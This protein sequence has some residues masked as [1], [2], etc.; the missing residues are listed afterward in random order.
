MITDST[1]VLPL[2]V[3]A[4]GAILAAL[5]G[6]PALNR[7]ITIT[8]ASW[9]LALAPLLAFILLLL[10]VPALNDGAIF[11]WTW[12]WLPSLGLRLGFYVD[13][14]SV[15]FGLLITFIG[16]LVIVYTGQYFKGEQK[17]WRFLTYM[18]LFMVSMLGIVLAGDVITLFIFW[19]GTSILSFLLVA[20]KTKDKDARYGAFRA[21]F[22]TG[23]G[24]IAMLG[25]LLFVSYVA[26]GTDFVT[27]LT[28]G[29][30][31][32]SNEFYIV[33]LLLVTFGAFTKS[34]QFPAHIWLPGAM[35]APT[36]ASAYLHSATM[37][38][39]GIYLLARMNPALGFTE[40]WFWLLTI[41]GGMTM[42]TG[43]YL[44]LKQNDLKALLAYSTI[45]QLGVLVM[46]IGQDIAIAYKALVVGI[47]AHALYK[48]ALFLVAGIVDHETGTR[49]IRRL[50]G[51]RKVM[52]FTFATA[53]LAALSMAGLP[54][55]FGFLAKETLL[56]T[57]VHPTLPPVIAEVIRW[58]TVLAGAL[59]LAQAGL[60]I[61]E[62]FMGKPKDP[63]VKGHEAP[64]PMWLAP[65]IPAALSLFLAI[66][67]EA[68]EEAPFLAGAAT[69]AF[70]D[71]VK[72]TTTLFHG[73][74]VE[75]ALS[76]VAIS[77][78]T[79]IF[80]FRDRVRA[81]QGRILPAATF[82]KLY[83][84]VLAGID[85]GGFIATRVQQGNL[86]TYLVIIISST[87]L[88][89]F[90]LV[91]ANL[92]FE[93]VRLTTPELSFAGEM[94][95]LRV[96]SLFLVVTAAAATVVLRR[97]FAAVMAFG[98]SGLSMALIFVLEPA[99]DVAL[100]QIVVDMLS[101]VILVL[102]LIRLPRRQRQQAQTL[103][104]Q[105]RIKY[106]NGVR[107]AIVAGSLGFLVF[108]IT[109]FALISRPH[110]SDVTPYYLDNAKKLTGATDVVGAIVVDFRALDTVI[111]IGV[112]S[113]AGLGIYT[114]LR[115]A[116]RKHGDS[117]QS[118]DIDQ[119]KLQAFFTR[120]IGGT[121]ISPFIRLSVLVSLPL[122]MLLAAT[123][124]MYGHDQPGDG[125][126]AG[127]IISLSIGLWY[128]VFGYE[129]TRR[130]LPWLR[131]GM[132][133]SSGILLAMVTGTTAALITGSFLGNV[134]FTAGWSFLP[135]GFHIST[136]FLLEV[137]ICVTVL[138][139]VAY[140]LNTLG[141]PEKDGVI[142]ESD[143]Y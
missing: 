140:M 21:L 99:P 102:A 91:R 8:Q 129:E 130:Q 59:M 5:L 87:V 3:I 75:L 30:V 19:E 13:S 11:V 1:L 74:T 141:R 86:R 25:G 63:S 132:L 48:S 9:V 51:L 23:G 117:G 43:A 14:L 104:D 58:S 109:L 125:F 118:A 90:G 52:P 28:S 143:Q 29:D 66:Y 31:L 50:G 133:I 69:A 124:M 92:P 41:V 82:N 4:V 20:Y 135:T 81:W 71:S 128:V 10:R 78:G 47:L 65:A 113:V 18:L 142:F 62:T 32:R 33:F 137:A 24:G 136:S 60:F 7:R 12:E 34:A 55:M 134:D 131:A 72:V 83:S 42:L 121:N 53:V 112:F 80:V 56:A 93:L 39:A 79:L 35:S 22:I 97:D 122:A 95:V 100:V 44:G 15:L 110:V 45:S 98:V 76:I 111:E 67:P 119:R 17:T 107:D 116:A 106:A 94:V 96:F 64:V 139:S 77:L 73:L 101:L 123:H 115:Y 40:T 85:K 46:L 38:K 138:G 57:A 108:L 103:T 127:V 49:D 54:P 88:L 37:V 114:L 120:G 61:W 89:V 26:G 2:I 126:T 6:R 36:P 70:G 84:W 68:K 16:T 105:A 27:I